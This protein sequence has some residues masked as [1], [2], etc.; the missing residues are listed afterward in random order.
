MQPWIT[1]KSDMIYNELLNIIQPL[2]VACT[3]PA[4]ISP[5]LISGVD[6]V[7]QMGLKQRTTGIVCSPKHIP[8][9]ASHSYGAFDI[10]FCSPDLGHWKLEVSLP[11][12]HLSE[13]N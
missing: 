12:V 10:W 11:K 2:Y 5:K 3:E 8:A 9:N 6:D 7:H 1:Y 4:L 13:S